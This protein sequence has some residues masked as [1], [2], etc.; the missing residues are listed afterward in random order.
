LWGHLKAPVKRLGAA[1][2][3]VPFS[4]PLETAFVPQPADIEAAIRALV[5]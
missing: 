3:P 5:A 4:K 1:F 2:A